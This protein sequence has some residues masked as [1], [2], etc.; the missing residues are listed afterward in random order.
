M[1]TELNKNGELD[2]SIVEDVTS[3]L[4]TPV[5]L[6]K[7][8]LMPGTV[9]K[10]VR[11]TGKRIAVSVELVGMG[12]YYVDPSEFPD[13]K[14]PAKHKTLIIGGDLE[15]ATLCDNSNECE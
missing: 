2:M 12:N 8:A 6:I 3:W 13:P 15:T 9:D 7:S 5:I 4:E 11:K 1:P 10:L 14:N